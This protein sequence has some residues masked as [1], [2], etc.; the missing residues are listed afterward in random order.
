MLVTQSQFK[1]FEVAADLGHQWNVKLVGAVFTSR[2]KPVSGCHANPGT[3]ILK[4]RIVGSYGYGSM[5][6]V[7]FALIVVIK[8]ILTI[9]RLGLLLVV[10]SLYPEL[11]LFSPAIASISRNAGMS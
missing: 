6:V 2:I 11:Q 10:F 7:V 1:I 4:Q 3:D 8:I 9:I 5:G